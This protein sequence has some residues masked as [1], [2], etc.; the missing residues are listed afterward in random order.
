MFS[1]GPWAGVQSIISIQA[2]GFILW[3]RLAGLFIVRHQVAGGY[4]HCPFRALLK[5]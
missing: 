2:P 3:V 4:Q 5:I 1:A